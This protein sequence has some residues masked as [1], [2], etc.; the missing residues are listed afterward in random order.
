MWILIAGSLGAS[1]ICCIS[2]FSFLTT[3]NNLAFVLIRCRLWERERGREE[4]RDFLWDL[5]ETKAGMYVL[6]NYLIETWFEWMNT[7]K[8]SLAKKE[9]KKEY[10]SER[11]LY[12]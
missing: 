3:T 12:Y 11:A 10:R 8:E 4:E 6:L 5:K 1:K 2:E 9:K 7:E